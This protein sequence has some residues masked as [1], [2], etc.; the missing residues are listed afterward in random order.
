[1]NKP[2]SIVEL[3]LKY[4]YM[5]RWRYGERI[6]ISF[7]LSEMIRKALI[8]EKIKAEYHFNATGKLVVTKCLGRDENDNF[9]N[10][11]NENLENQKD[12]IKRIIVGVLVS[13]YNQLISTKGK[14]L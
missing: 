5:E 2:N 1:M 4:G 3:F 14:K 7:E 9:Y 11:E 6:E 12:R 8:S 13:K 10:E